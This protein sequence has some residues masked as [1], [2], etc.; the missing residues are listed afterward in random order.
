MSWC[1]IESDPGVFNEMMWSLGA[2]KVAVREIY[3]LDDIAQSNEP[4]YGLIFLFKWVQEVDP[5]PIASEQDTEGLIFA[6]QIAT[7]ACA[8]QAL[9]SVLLNAPDV[10]LGDELTEFKGFVSMLDPETRGMAI[11]NADHIREVHNSFARPEPFLNEE[12][13]NE[14]AEKEDAHHFVAFVPFNGSVYE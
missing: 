6:R 9:L 3:S 10:E 2:Q 12:V 8:T 11:E 4:S 5:R 1:T 14:N 13:K 7:N